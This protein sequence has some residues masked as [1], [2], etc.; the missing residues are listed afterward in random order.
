MA[1]LLLTAFINYRRKKKTA[2]KRRKI[3]EPA[4]ESGNIKRDKTRQEKTKVETDHLGKKDETVKKV[5]VNPKPFSSPKPE[6]STHKMTTTPSTTLE[7]DWT[8]T[9]ATRKE[10]PTLTTTVLTFR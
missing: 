5:D 8:T 3:G 10:P 4:V 2:A 1:N 6:T 7:A 9:T